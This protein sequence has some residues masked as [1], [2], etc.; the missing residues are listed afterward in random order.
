[1]KWLIFTVSMMWGSTSWAASDSYKKMA[2]DLA[3]GINKSIQ[4][5]I[6]A[7][8]A[9][10]YHTGEE[11]S[12]STI[13]SERLTTRLA[14]LKNLKIVERRLIQKLFEEE[15]LNESG[16]IDPDQAQNIG[17]ILGVNVI[18]TGTL[19]DINDKTEIN[20]RA[21]L[22]QNGEVIAVSQALVERTWPQ[23]P[24]KILPKNNPNEE[25][26]EPEV[27]NKAIEIGIPAPRGGGA[28][29]RRY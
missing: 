9:F 21:I 25:I 13:I 18:V 14:N 22:A 12:G 27:Q 19:N 29:G 8:L 5:P 17:K 1:M 11:N 3:K 28:G 20:T 24:R 10:P 23:K 6:V 15:K 26:E 2:Q 7:V 4:N 16:V